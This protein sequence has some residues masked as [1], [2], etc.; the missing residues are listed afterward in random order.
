MSLQEYKCEKLTRISVRQEL[1]V[2]NLESDRR[3]GYGGTFCIF[4]DVPHINF[5]TENYY[6]GS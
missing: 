5:G 1:P 6:S 3:D 2:L 4:L